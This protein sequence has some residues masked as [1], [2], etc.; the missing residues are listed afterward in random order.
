MKLS[1]YTLLISATQ[2][3]RMEPLDSKPPGAEGP[4]GT[5]VIAEESQGLKCQLVFKFPEEEPICQLQEAP[6]EGETDMCA[7]LID[8]KDCLRGRVLTQEEIDAQ[9]TDLESSV[10]TEEAKLFDGWFSNYFN[11]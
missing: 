6:A 9:G 4:D 3:I 10:M 11:F 8:D 1:T 2:A 7:E 5:E